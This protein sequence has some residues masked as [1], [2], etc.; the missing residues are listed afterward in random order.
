[1]EN[2]NQEVNPLTE[3]GKSGKEFLSVLGT[4]AKN[5]FNAGKVKAKVFFENLN[6]KTKFYNEVV[7]EPDLE[8]RKEA[9]E[10]LYR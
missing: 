9:F 5:M 3:I 2:N 10:R 1:M 7:L 4:N 8:K 6:P